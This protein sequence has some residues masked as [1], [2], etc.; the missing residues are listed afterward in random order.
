MDI[1]AILKAK[2]MSDTD[3]ETMTTNPLFTDLIT[4]Y[5]NKAE[6]GETAY[7]NALAAKKELEDWNKNQIQ[8]Y[9]LQA[10]AKTRAAEAKAAAQSAY[11]KSLKDQGYEIPDAMLDAAAPVN[12]NPNPNPAPAAKDYSEDLVNATKANM[13]LISMSERAR[14]LLGHGLDVESEYEDFGKNRRPNENLRSYITRKYDLDSKQREKDATALKAKEDALREEGRKA[15]A[16]EYAQKYGDNPNTAIP[17]ASK[18]DS[19]VADNTRKDS[20]RTPAAREASSRS[21]MEKYANA[22]FLN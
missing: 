2:G 4:E 5:A 17:R 10:D 6:Q 14:D 19:I 1:K 11:L 7:Q 9:V 16:A 21:R 18:F 13:A 20:W 15:A 3:I 8:P 12:P 22:P